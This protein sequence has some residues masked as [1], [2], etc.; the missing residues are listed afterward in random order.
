MRKTAYL[1]IMLALCLSLMS[2]C[3]G[4][5]GSAASGG[6]TIHIAEL[7]NDVSFID[8]SAGDTA[9]QLLARVDSAGT[10]KLSYNTCQ[11]CKG[12]PYAYFEVQN[13]ALICR[14]CGNLFSFDAIGETSAVGCMP[15]ALN[16]YT[17]EDG[18][19]IIAAET[20]DSMKNIFSNWK[21]GL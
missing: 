15:I 19:V 21:K 18:Q 20:L 9:M 14:N 7:T 3:A 16:D 12:S 6:L 13:N 10:P 11:S 4:K 1:I 5:D 2:G 8:Y 17:V